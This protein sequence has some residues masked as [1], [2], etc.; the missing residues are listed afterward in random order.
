MLKCTN[1]KICQK[2]LS[3]IILLL[4]VSSW[5]GLEISAPSLV[6]IKNFFN[7]SEKTVGLTM[8]CFF[9]GISIMSFF[10]GPASDLIGRRKILIF[11]LI[12]SCIGG[13]FTVFGQSIEII[14]LGRFI[15][16][17]GTA[18][19][20]ALISVIISDAFGDRATKM[21]RINLGFTTIFTALG[22][23]IGGFV[24]NAIGFRANY[25]I[26]LLL[27]LFS[28][29][30]VY[31][32]FMES[33]IFDDQHEK[34]LS[35]K[36]IFFKL[37]D[38]IKVKNFIICLLIPTL[39]YSS[40]IGFVN[41]AAFLY[42]ETFGLNDIKYSIFQTIMLFSFS[43]TNLFFGFIKYNH[44]IWDKR[45]VYFSSFLVFISYFLILFAKNQYQLTILM[46]FALCGHAILSPLFFAKIFSLVKEK[47][48][49]S[50]VT[51]VF[52][53][54]LM[55]FSTWTFILFYNGSVFNLGALL[56]LNFLIVLSCIFILFRSK[57]FMKLFD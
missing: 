54:G 13:L 5:I 9:L 51:G 38:A 23:I 57:S 39:M 33:L 52:R 25:L 56:F 15:Q 11:G 3:I 27:Q 46:S 49:A 22:P 2:L 7:V 48:S 12:L 28:L 55:V 17:L 26:V 18:A 8:T 53:S 21:M 20:I 32:F 35:P 43:I 16:G 41:Y 10:Y 45:L 47:G 36:K 14:I 6:S 1:Q 40:F 29:F 4:T 42:I 19:P 34:K 50:S 30:L 37:R 24:N 44:K 31:V